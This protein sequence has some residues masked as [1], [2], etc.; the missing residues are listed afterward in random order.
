MPVEIGSRIT[1]IDADLR[2]GKNSTR[3]TRI[4]RNEQKKENINVYRGRYVNSDRISDR[5]QDKVHK[6]IYCVASL[7]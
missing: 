2:K 5:E 1:R 3:I 4:S 7:E 6:V